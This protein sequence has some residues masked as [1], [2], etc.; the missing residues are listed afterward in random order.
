MKES[1]FYRE[2]DNQGL[3]RE[4]QGRKSKEIYLD[5]GIHKGT[6]YNWRKKY[7]GME[8]SQLKELKSSKRRTDD[9][10]RCMLI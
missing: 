3:K 6:F 1:K 10:S 9:S 8:A 7:S 5:L 2:P 4:Q